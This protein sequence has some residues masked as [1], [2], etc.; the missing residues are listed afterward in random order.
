MGAQKL[1][2][3]FGSTTVVGHI[4][5]QLLHSAVDHVIVVVGHEADR[6]VE[7]L[8]DRSVDIVTNPDYKTGMLSSVRCGLRVVLQQAEGVMV[9]L[10]DQPAITSSLVDEMLEAF[11]TTDKSIL[12]P[13]YAGRR[14]HPLLFAKHFRDEI[15]NSFD[16]A[17]LRGLLQVHPDDVFELDA[18]TPAVLSDMDQPEDYQRELDSL[19]EKRRER[20]DVDE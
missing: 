4:V 14:G 6:I 9:A 12:V 5:D 13:V 10:G 20:T 18:S 15:L 2:L 11:R 8:S 16:D 3:P 1:L 7:E 17:G 19:E